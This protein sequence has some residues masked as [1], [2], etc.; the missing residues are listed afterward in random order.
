MPQA[1]TW[2]IISAADKYNIDLK[3][4]FLIGDRWKDI[5]AGQKAG[6]KTIWLNKK[7]NEINPKKDPDLQQLN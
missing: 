6:C 5:E 1:L 2:I 3:K 4:S 7:Y